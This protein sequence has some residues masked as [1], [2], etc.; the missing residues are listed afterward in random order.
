MAQSPSD[1]CVM[2]GG[3]HKRDTLL[4]VHT[5]L[6][7]FK[8]SD[9]HSIHYQQPRRLFFQLCCHHQVVRAAL[10]EDISDISRLSEAAA[11]LLLA[12]FRNCGSESDIANFQVPNKSAS[13]TSMLV[14][15]TYTCGTS[16]ASLGMS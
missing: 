16:D 7:N 11:R 2:R 9:P 13:M 4:P 14:E 5:L 3:I 12:N 6:A 10:C 8:V 15:K 1:N